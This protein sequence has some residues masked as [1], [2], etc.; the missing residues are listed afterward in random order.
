MVVP[1]ICAGSFA[2]SGMATSVIPAITDTPRLSGTGCSFQLMP[3]QIKVPTPALRQSPRQAKKHWKRGL[4]I[5]KRQ[6]TLKEAVGNALG[7]PVRDRIEN[8]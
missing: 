4:N 2:V 1:F 5:P 7:C 3:L 6:K 8:F